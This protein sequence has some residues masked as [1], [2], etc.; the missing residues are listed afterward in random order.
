MLPGVNAH[1]RIAPKDEHVHDWLLRNDF[2]TILN[3]KENRHNK[4]LRALLNKEFEGEVWVDGAMHA[5]EKEKGKRGHKHKKDR[6]QKS[7]TH[8]KPQKKL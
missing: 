1:H 4:D 8:D 2:H 3:Y 5:G 6:R 7:V